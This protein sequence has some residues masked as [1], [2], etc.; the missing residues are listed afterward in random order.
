[1]YSV[2]GGDGEKVYSYEDGI[3]AIRAGKEINYDGVTGS[4]EYT[5]TG[6]VAGIFGIFEWQD[7]GTISQV[8]SVSA[9]DVL[10]LEAM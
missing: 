4:M 5:D 8:G 10:A 6:I 2:T 9:D 3:A 1:M 7:D